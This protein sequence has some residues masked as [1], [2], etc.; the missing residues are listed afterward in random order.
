MEVRIGAACRLLIEEEKNIAEVAYECGYN[1]ISHFNQQFK[2]V[3]GK[4]PMEYRKDYLNE[5]WF[6]LFKMNKSL[7]KYYKNNYLQFVIFY[8]SGCSANGIPA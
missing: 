4:T 7:E 5:S 8:V 3:T 1:T 6:F 2:Q